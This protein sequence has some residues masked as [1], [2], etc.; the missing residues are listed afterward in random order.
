MHIFSHGNQ[1]ALTIRAIIPLSKTVPL[2]F[3]HKFIEKLGLGDSALESLTET[4]YPRTYR[5][6]RVTNRRQRTGQDAR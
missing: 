2:F 1:L 3:Q 5:P 4:C 6:V